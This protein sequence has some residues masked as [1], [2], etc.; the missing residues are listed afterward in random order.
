MIETNAIYVIVMRE[1]KKFIREKSRLIST[2]ARPLLWLFLIGGACRVLFL[3]AKMFLT[4]NSSF[5][6]SSA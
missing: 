4:S 3:P 2:L 1:F 6:A 5:R